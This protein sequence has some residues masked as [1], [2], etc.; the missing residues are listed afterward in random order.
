[1]K[2]NKHNTIV[3]SEIER[4]DERIDQTGEVFTPIE[5]CIEMVNEIPLDVIQNPQSKFLDNSAGNGNFMIALLN[6][7]TEYHSREHVL[8]HMLYAVELMA[9]NHKEM[10]ERLGVDTTHPHYVCCDALTYD[11]SFGEP[12]GVEEFFSD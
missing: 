5:L 2:K 3:G 8:N 1:M 12:M 6:K 11:Y 9:D 7:L 10:C 4:T